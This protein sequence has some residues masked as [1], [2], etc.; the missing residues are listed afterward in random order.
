MLGIMLVLNALRIP[1]L[2]LRLA[3]GMAVWTGVYTSG[4]H[5]T[6]AGVLVA[7]AFPNKALSPTVS[8]EPALLH[9]LEDGLHPW[10]AGLIIPLF[11]FANAG[12]SLTRISFEGG[13]RD[14]A[15]GVGVALVAGKIIG[16]FSSVRIT[17]ALGLARLPRGV[18]WLQIF[19]LA[20]LCGIGFTM[21]LFVSLLAFGES[22]PFGE[23]TKLGVLAG[24]LAS[25]VFGFLTL[26]LARR[27][28]NFQ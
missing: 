5:A 21:S 4:V 25:A 22:T 12:V 15:V 13:T 20:C 18:S 11:G 26:R 27:T 6:I 14:V 9:R 3:L 2:T 17:C 16:I 7:F 1:S 19:G 23:A 8:D 24:S 28:S 10:V